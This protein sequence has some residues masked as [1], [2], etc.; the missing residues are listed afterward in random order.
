MPRNG[1]IRAFGLALAAGTIAGSAV[2]QDR[3]DFSSGTAHGTMAAGAGIVRVEF[4]RNAFVQNQIPVPVEMQAADGWNSFLFGVVSAESDMMILSRGLEVTQMSGQLVTVGEFHMPLGMEPNGEVSRVGDFGVVF[5]GGQIRLRDR[6]DVLREL[7]VFAP[8]PE[9]I[10]LSSDASQLVISAPLQVS[11]SLANEILRTPALEGLV[12]GNVEVNV[13][14]RVVDWDVPVM[15]TETGEQGGVAGGTPNGPDVITSNI[16]TTINLY[17]TIGGISAYA[18]TTVSCN[19]GEQDAEWFANVARHPVIAQNM[20]RLK[21]VDGAKQ[22]EQIGMSWLKHGWCAADAPSCGSPYE[23]NGSCDWLGTHATDTYGAGLN[24][25]QTDLGPRS[26]VNPWAGTYPYPYVLGWNATGNSIYKR[27]QVAAADLNPSQN[28]GA[29]YWAEGHYV[30]TDEQPINR[31]NNV[32]HRRILVGSA[33]GGGYN[34]SFTGSSITQQPAINQWP[35][36]DPGATLVNVDVPSDGRLIVGY[37]VTDIGGGQYHYEYAI[38]NMNSHRA[39]QSFSIPVPAGVTISNIGFHD[40]PYHSGEP[41]SGTDWPGVVASGA[42]TWATDTFASNQ[43]ANAIR[44]GTL[45]NFRF[46]ANAPPGGATATIGLFRTGSPSSLDVSVR[47]P[48]AITVD[49]PVITQH[50]QSQ[51]LCQG[52][53]VTFTVAAT[54]TGPLSYQWRKDTVNISGANGTSYTITNVTTANAGSYD[55]VVT[56]SAGSAT[57]NPAV[58]TVQTAP[59]ISQQPS[60]QSICEGQPVTFTVVASG[61]P[62]PSYQW[63]KNGVPISG[64]TGSSY[65]IPSVSAADAGNYQCSVVNLCGGVQSAIAILTINSAPSIS[66]HPASFNVC[67]GVGVVFSVTASG[68]PAPSYQWRKDGV[69]ISGATGSSYAIAAVGAG[70]A[71]SYTC[72][73]SN[74]CGSTTSNAG[75]LAVT[76]KA[77]ANCDGTVNNFD[78]DAFVMG[79]VEGQAA[80]NAAGYTCDYYCALDINGDGSVDNFDIDPFTQCLITL[81]CP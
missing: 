49:P 63:R 24:A 72:V 79:L 54:G 77:D 73:V 74:A 61:D 52:D 9:Q 13:T 7:F 70:D 67:S 21:T 5:M 55:C 1:A 38:Y 57:S 81:G 47:G 18:M 32:T 80:W 45:Y 29:L 71:G 16:G 23:A 31:Y 11:W 33:S 20:Y 6:L 2:A 48:Q 64:A 14:L 15:P 28:S 19:L 25:D 53:D 41:F 46:D 59:V 62:A 27:L 39:V 37:N 60:S 3:Y 69:D 17:G 34:L 66:Q 65:T 43:N 26:E 12:V 36:N 30:C 35:L 44:W 76:V 8:T 22:F 51:T 50:P 4:D 42:I 58:L 68:T 40:V 78:I 75:T 10:V 56:N